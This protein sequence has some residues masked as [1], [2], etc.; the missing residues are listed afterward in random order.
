[1]FSFLC[2][3]VAAGAQTVYTRTLEVDHGNGLV[4]VPADAELGDKQ[5]DE[6]SFLSDRNE[7]LQNSEIIEN[8][9]NLLRQYLH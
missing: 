1:M 9:G 2:A 5:V 8:Q 6:N 4:K 7:T 3:E